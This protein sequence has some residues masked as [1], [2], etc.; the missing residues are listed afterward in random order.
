MAL[1]GIAWFLTSC[2]HALVHGSLRGIVTLQ[3]V[4]A[5]VVTGAHFAFPSA[6]KWEQLPWI[7]GSA[8]AGVL[9]GGL[10]SLVIGFG[11]LNLP[12]EVAATIRETRSQLPTTA[13]PC[14]SPVERLEELANLTNAAD[15]LV[16]GALHVRARLT[17]FRQ[18]SN[19]RC[20]ST[21]Q[22]Q[23]ARDHLVPGRNHPGYG[24][25]SADNAY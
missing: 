24:T 22:H 20:A 19:R 6:F 2:W 14:A 23:L 18:G 4:Y 13:G 8:I 11:R 5:L 17:L 1:V 12:R 16:R 10:V 3:M 21:C 9:L 15:T 25:N 7:I